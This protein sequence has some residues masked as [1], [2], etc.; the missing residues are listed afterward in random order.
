MSGAYTSEECHPARQSPTL[1]GSER[2]ER[3][4][5]CKGQMSEQKRNSP[6]DP[7]RI[8]SVL[9]YVPLEP[10]RSQGS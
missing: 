9:D 2:G 8:R 4:K 5:G 3:E 6:V 10:L 7:V 1:S